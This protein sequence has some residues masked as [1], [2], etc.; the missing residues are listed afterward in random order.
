[1]LTTHNTPYKNKGTY[2][3]E[4]Y[5]IQIMRF[6]EEMITLRKKYLI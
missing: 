6:D 4:G 3:N 5:T 1:M 2:K